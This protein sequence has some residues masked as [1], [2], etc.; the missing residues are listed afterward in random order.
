MPT[1]VTAYQKQPL[2]LPNDVFLIL[3]IIAI[4]SCLNRLVTFLWH[5]F[6]LNFLYCSDFQAFLISIRH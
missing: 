5:L 4:E 2:F 6:L 1:M 3:G